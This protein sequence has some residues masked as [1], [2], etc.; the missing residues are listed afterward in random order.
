P[1]APA[2]TPQVFTGKVVP[3]AS[4]KG[5]SE[6]KEEQRGVA[7]VAD[8]GASYP[9]A[10]DDCSR[11]LFVDKHLQNRPVRLTRFVAPGTKNLRVVRAQLV[12]DGKIYDFDYW[13][14]QSQISL[15][16]PGP[17]YCCGDEAIFRE[18]LAK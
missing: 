1:P 17:C 18:R 13:C 4:P 14:D 7:L 11:M 9:L 12:K 15:L 10:E 2:E 16:H 8:D 5:K 3:V 6:A